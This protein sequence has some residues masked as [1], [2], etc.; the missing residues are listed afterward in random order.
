MGEGMEG[1]A[2]L[3][4][5]VLG[6]LAAWVDGQVVSLGG[7]KQRLVLAG[8]LSN[9]NNVVSVDRL[10]DILW[11]DEPPEDAASTLAKYVSRLRVALRANV[12]G[13]LST[14][15]PGYVL[16]V[17]ADQLDAMR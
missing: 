12:D 17:T 1:F 4:F 5:G 7:V 6:P 10:V 9:A 13:P 16:S 15:S 8:L 3:R 2:G 11:G 14:R